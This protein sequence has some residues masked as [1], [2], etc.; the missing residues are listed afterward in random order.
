VGKKPPGLKK[1]K[2]Y[3]GPDEGKKVEKQE[4]SKH[5]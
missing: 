3:A 1:L 4:K 2:D 5:W